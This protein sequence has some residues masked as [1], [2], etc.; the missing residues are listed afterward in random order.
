M[1]VYDTLKNDSIENMKNTAEFFTVLKIV[2]ILTVLKTADWPQIQT[3]PF[4]WV[5]TVNQGEVK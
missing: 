4:G 3:Y 2:N 1:Q 5:S